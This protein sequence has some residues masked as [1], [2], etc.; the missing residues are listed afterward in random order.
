MLNLL[1]DPIF[2][3]DLK[4]DRK[5]LSLPETYAALIA[6]R[7]DYFPALRPFQR[8]P[9]HAFLCQTAALALISAGDTKAPARASDWRAL[10]TALTPDYPD[11]EPWH[12]IAPDDSPAFLQPPA[13]RI[14]DYKQTA[15]SPEDIDI[16]VNSKHLKH[17][18]GIGASSRPED[19][20]YALISLQTQDGFGGAGNYGIF[21]MNGGLGSR[22]GIGLSPSLRPGPAVKRDIEALAALYADIK[23]S[24]APNKTLI[25][26]LWTIPWSGSKE[27]AIDGLNTLHPLCVEICRRI[28][29]QPTNAGIKALKAT[30]KAPRVNAKHLLGDTGDPWTP[31]DINTGKSLTITARGF[32]RQRI[33]GILT[34]DPLRPPPMAIPTAAELAGGELYLIARATARGQGRTEGYHER[35]TPIGMR[36]RAA[37]A[38]PDSPNM[39]ALRELFAERAESADIARRITAHAVY[40][41]ASKDGSTSS[42]TA[43]PRASQ[44]LTAFSDA[45]DELFI[46]SALA[47]YEEPAAEVQIQLRIDYHKR[48]AALSRQT[49]EQAQSALSTPANLA[50][51]AKIASTDALEL[52]L[53]RELL[54]ADDENAPPVYPEPTIWARGALSHAHSLAI[55][56]LTHS[57]TLT[58]LAKAQPGSTLIKRQLDERPLTRDLTP[59]EERLWGFIIRGLALTTPR[60]SRPPK[61]ARLAHDPRTPLGR[62]LYQGGNS[63]PG[64]GYIAETSLSRLL[65]SPNDQFH[66]EL[67]RDIQ[68]LS[69]KN[70]RFDWAETANLIAAAPGAEREEALTKVARD[71]YRA[72]NYSQSN[73]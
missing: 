45:L 12:L 59:Q 54:Q 63:Q 1:T 2:C 20:A 42:Q 15:I 44:H 21:R 22:P 17:K 73:R 25:P 4:G 67:M 68:K 37:I 46:Q 38:H 57:L 16:V 27:D 26:L 32:T 48:L 40:L 11:E 52:R 29:L 5:D 8:H 62:A 13:S 72:K 35:V 47:E 53:K 41:Y 49:L 43:D 31:I 33:T 55:L 70:A 7:V 56:N 14:A 71:Y 69:R 10:L 19:W 61:D 3:A 60:Q 58:R 28:R 66:A 65:T 39:N 6:D 9:W 50:Y 36:A 23:P 34:A 30:S 24:N 51:K 64:G 18:I